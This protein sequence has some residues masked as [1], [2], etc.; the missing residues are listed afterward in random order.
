MNATAQHWRN[1]VWPIDR[2][3]PHPLNPRTHSPEQIELVR[4]LIRQY[5]FTNPALVT[6]DGLI[7]AGH[8]RTEAAKAEGMTHVPV[9]VRDAAFPLDEAQIIGL[10][11]ADNKS[12]LNAGWD[13]D[14]LA[15]GMEVM[16]ASDFDMDLLG[17]DPVELS[18][19][20]GDILAAVPAAVKEKTALPHNEKDVWPVV[21]IQAPQDVH[22]RWADMVEAVCGPEMAPWQLFATLLDAHAQ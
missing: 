11:V 5:G 18:N 12:A 17:F 10:V 3:K 4:A 16:A 6:A 1:E 22:Q 21:T 19:I 15:Q 20:T 7:I 2:L 13:F 9:R 8:G 14:L